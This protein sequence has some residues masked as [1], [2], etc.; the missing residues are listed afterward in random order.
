VCAHSLVHVCWYR[1]TRRGSSRNL[2][3]H[4]GDWTRARGTHVNPIG[5]P[6]L[7]I[8]TDIGCSF[9]M[10][11]PELTFLTDLAR[12]RARSR[13]V[14]PANCCSYDGILGNAERLALPAI[15]GFISLAVQRWKSCCSCYCG[16]STY[17]D[18]PQ[19]NCSTSR[20]RVRGFNRWSI[21][22]P[23]DGNKVANCRLSRV[24]L[25]R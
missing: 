3:G 21:Q 13:S 25:K 18:I 16:N 20:G 15:G 12:A 17:A 14:A 10:Q 8:D 9:V 24:S 4:K 11:P 2:G 23:F 22:T 5:A 7:P 6:Y 19:E 1:L